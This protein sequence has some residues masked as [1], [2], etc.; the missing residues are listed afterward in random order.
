MNSSH[1][2]FP[3]FDHSE[4][5]SNMH[6]PAVLVG[7][8]RLLLWWREV[9]GD[10]SLKMEGLWMNSNTWGYKRRS[11]HLPTVTSLLKNN[12]T[13]FEWL[14]IHLYPFISIYYFCLSSRL[15]GYQ[16]SWKMYKSF[17]DR[18]HP[19]TPGCS[20]TTS[21]ENCV[22]TQTNWT[23]PRNTIW[24]FNIAMENHHL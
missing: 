22:Y 12:D 8:I 18:I 20:T 16:G 19:C 21:A 6:M 17:F 9:L 13:V 4:T 7:R 14:N 15:P 3:E 1:L 24:L 2:I 11:T 23:N 5:I 10:E